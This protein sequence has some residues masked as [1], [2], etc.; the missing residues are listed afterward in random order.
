MVFNLNFCLTIF[1]T[2]GL[3]VLK[4]TVLKKVTFIETESFMHRVGRRVDP[5]TNAIV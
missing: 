2:L 1:C 3:E 4:A 5:P